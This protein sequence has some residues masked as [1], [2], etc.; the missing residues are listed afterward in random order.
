[1]ADDVT[2]TVM[3]SDLHIPLI[4][5]QVKRLHSPHNTLMRKKKK[6]NKLYTT[7]DFM[8]SI[9]QYVIILCY[10]LPFPLV[11]TEPEMCTFKREERHRQQIQ[12]EQSERGDNGRWRCPTVKWHMEVKLKVQWRSSRLARSVYVK[13][14]SSLNTHQ[15]PHVPL[16]INTQRFHPPRIFVRSFHH[17]I[18]RQKTSTN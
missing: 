3:E 7:K 2:V 12:R 4:H 17:L 6:H 9:H 8:T 10:R 14:K 13:K 15:L 5:K 11:G 18:Y 16:L 1:M